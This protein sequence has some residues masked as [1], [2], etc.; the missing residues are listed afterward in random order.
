MAHDARPAGGDWWKWVLALL[1][2]ILIGA[3]AMASMS[4]WFV[5]RALLA[6]PEII[7]E[8][9]ERL[10]ERETAGAVS[11]RRAEFETPYRGAWAGAADGDVVLVEFFDY[12]CGYCRQMNPVIERLIAEDPRLKVVWRE[13]PVLG[14]DSQQAALASLTAAEAN[15]FKAFHDRLYALG[16][17]TPE[18]VAAAA[19]AVGIAPP[20]E[21]SDAHVTEIRRNMDL[22]EAIRANGTPTFVVGD[23]VLRG[24]VSYETLRDAV[25]AARAG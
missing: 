6:E 25:A 3:V 5:R 11:A 4:G 18:N 12:A 19:A 15:R 8:A 24:A 13:L 9:I 7:P 17:P 2:G 20:E 1:L 14:P 16:R 23:R 22:M 10:Q 21:P